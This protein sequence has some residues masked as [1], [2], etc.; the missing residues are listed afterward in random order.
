MYFGSADHSLDIGCWDLELAASSFV[1][2][3]GV[4]IEPSWHGYAT[5]SDHGTL[6]VYGIDNEDHGK[7]RVEERWV[8]AAQTFEGV[9]AATGRLSMPGWEQGTALP[10]GFFTWRF[11]GEAG[12]ELLFGAGDKLFTAPINENGL[13][14]TV[15]AVANPAGVRVQQLVDVGAHALLVDDGHHIYN[16]DRGLPTDPLTLQ[17]PIADIGAEGA[18]TGD[19]YAAH[20]WTYEGLFQIR[21]LRVPRR[22]IALGTTSLQVFYEGSVR[23]WPLV[24]VT[25][26]DVV[27]PFLTDAVI[28]RNLDEIGTAIAYVV[29]TFDECGAPDSQYLGVQT[30]ETA[31]PMLQPTQQVPLEVGGLPALVTGSFGSDTD[32]DLV[33]IYPRRT[34]EDPPTHSACYRAATTTSIAPCP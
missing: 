17:N 30:Y 3:G 10:A 26:E 33:V 7:V 1:R 13:G 18:E 6:F 22:T 20:D 24:G 31:H 29:T 12:Q 28:T 5:S 14:V 15:M 9:N 8:G 16:L 23:D 4:K 11:V 32:R 34:A 2:I 21:G 19:V 25:P 27:G